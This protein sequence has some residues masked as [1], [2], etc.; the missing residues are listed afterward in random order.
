MRIVTMWHALE[1]NDA[2]S[3]FTAAHS[4]KGICGNMGVM[5]M[6][7]ISQELQAAG[8]DERLAGVEERLH[9]VEKEF[10][11]VKEELQREFCFSESKA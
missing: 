5:R 4:L 1:L 2:N 11:Q 8:R 3:F 9:A 10:E 7:H 6:M